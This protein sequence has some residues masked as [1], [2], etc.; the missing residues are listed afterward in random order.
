[1]ATDPNDLPFPALELSQHSIAPPPRPRKDPPALRLRLRLPD[2]GRPRVVVCPERRE[3]EIIAGPR[4]YRPGPALI[5]I[6][7]AVDR[8]LRWLPRDN[9]A[10][11][12]AVTKPRSK[13]LAWPMMS[14]ELARLRALGLITEAMFEAGVEYIKLLADYHSVMGSPVLA[15]RPSGDRREKLV[16]TESEGDAP[17]ETPWDA[18]QP[19][20]EMEDFPSGFESEL[21]HAPPPP[22][23]DDEG[24]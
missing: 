23:S 9:T 12:V 22:N 15:T 10:R 1:M 18:P 13:K 4:R 5:R 11:I 3:I 16:N 19:A 17:R 24:E 14:C 20:F 21:Q 6:K 2:E 8:D 7:R